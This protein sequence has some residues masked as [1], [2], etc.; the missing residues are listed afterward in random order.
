MSETIA[1][2]GL[3]NMGTPIAKN[4]IASGY[5][6]KLYNRSAEKVEGLV[7]LG[8]HAAATIGEAVKSADIVITMLSDDHAV[9]AV[10]E[11]ILPALKKGSIHLSMSTIKADTSKQLA[12]KHE[13]RGAVYLASPVMGRPPA[14]EA[15]QLFILLSGDAAAREKVKPVLGAIGQRTFDFGDAPY[16]SHTVKLMMNFMIFTI[17]ELLSEVMLMAEKSGIDKNILLD[18]M[19]NTIYG[20]PVVKVYGPLIIKE[21]DNP[22]GFGTLLANKDLRLAQETASEVGAHLPLAEV[23]R[24]HFEAII[25]AGGGRKDLPMLVSYLREQSEEVVK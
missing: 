12:K 13:A 3:G 15:R 1:F 18:T 22:N 4:L 2:I 6:V 14:A 20:A 21:E 9:N 24:T 16:T 7:A 19:L 5:T 8:G 17:V 25:A 23:V 10:S 11:E